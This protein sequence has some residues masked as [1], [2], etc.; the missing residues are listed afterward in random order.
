MLLEAGANMRAR[1]RW[2]STPYDDAVRHRAVVE[3]LDEHERTTAGS[4]PPL[5]RAASLQARA[6]FLRSPAPM[7]QQLA[8]GG[9]AGSAQSGS[10]A[11]AAGPGG[12]AMRGAGS[13]SRSGE[14]KEAAAASIAAAR[15]PNAGAL[16]PESTRTT[17]AASAD[18][19]ALAAPSF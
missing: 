8:A 12:S 14:R 10:A 1:D 2:G 4:L 7:G 17:R 19:F 18:D 16:S 3:L 15:A 6:A 5:R 13:R 11:A 9:S